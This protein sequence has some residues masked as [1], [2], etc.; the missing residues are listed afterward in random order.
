MPMLLRIPVHADAMVTCCKV[1][2]KC[3]V[4]SHKAPNVFLNLVMFYIMGMVVVVFF[5]L[6]WGF[7][8]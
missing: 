3:F 1:W 2:R 8:F 6:L 4:K 7:F 5:L